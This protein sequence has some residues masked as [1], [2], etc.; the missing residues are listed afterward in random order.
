MNFIKWSKDILGLVPEANI[1]DNL[2][3]YQISAGCRLRIPKGD[4]NY[5]YRK[6]R[7]FLKRSIFAELLEVSVKQG[8]SGGRRNCGKCVGHLS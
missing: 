8:I 2:P 5:R 4:A 3:E 1:K 6:Y 7:N